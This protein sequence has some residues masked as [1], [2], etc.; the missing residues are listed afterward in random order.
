MSN[1][2]D[3]TKQVYK[4]YV[5]YLI[6]FPIWKFINKC[7]PDWWLIY[8]NEI[9]CVFASFTDLSSSA[10]PD[11]RAVITCVSSY[12]HTFSG[13][14]KVL[15]H[16]IYTNHNENNA[17]DQRVC[18]NVA[19][20]MLLKIMSESIWLKNYLTYTFNIKEMLVSA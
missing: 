7:L 9:L 17:Y 2:F 16:D 18:F 6:E 19:S 8:F 1:S 14:Q 12:Y 3:N 20:T 4:S 13:V 10:K 5:I 15:K 11:E